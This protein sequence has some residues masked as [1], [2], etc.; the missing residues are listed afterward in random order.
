MLDTLRKY[1]SGWVA[2]LLMAVLVLSFAVWGVSD[3]F[4]GFGANAIAQVGDA[5][6]SLAEF[7]RRYDLALRTLSARLGQNISPQQA[8]QFGVP[9]QVLNQ[10]VF[11]ATLSHAASQMGIG[12][13]DQELGRK[14]TE[15]PNLF[16]PSGTFDRAY[17]NNLIAAQR[18][19]EDQFIIDRRQ[20]YIRD[21]IV[22]AFGGGLEAPDAYMRAIH[23]YTSE[24]RTISYLVV[25]APA[26]ADIPDPSEA[27]LA[28]Y[29][30]AHKADWR[31]PELRALQYFTLSPDQIAN[32]ADVSDAA[33]EQRYNSQPARFSTPE[34]RDVQQI[35]FKDKAAA[36]A[37]A[38]AL[39]AGKTFDDIVAEQKLKPDD[40]DLGLVT[41]DKIVDP[42][43]AKA[44]F[45]LPEGGV[46]GVIDGQFGPVILHVTRI[47]PAVE[48][49]FADVKDTLKKEIATER[50]ANDIVDLHNAIEDARAGGATL[51]EVAA[52]YDLKLVTVPAVDSDGNGAD[53]QPV[54]DLP[55]GLVAAAFQSDV[56]LENNPIEPDRNSYAWY[57]V[58]KT[59]PPRD[60]TLGEVHDRVVA[61]WKTDQR[62]QK[63]TAAS[64]DAR[65][66]LAG[67]AEIA[68]VASGL[69]LTVQT[70][71]HLT[72]R[73]QPTGDLS[74]A[75]I[76]AAFTGPKGTVEAADGAKPMTRVVLVVEEVSTPPYFSG[77]P[78][79]A[80]AQVQLSSQ[81]ENDLLGL[82]G[83]EVQTH[84]E[85]RLNQAALQQA[86]GVSPN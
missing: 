39:N 77:A 81:M 85:V 82:Y 32:P 71:D 4:S 5:K 45:S 69:S 62:Q 51:E 53:G 56:G 80:Q 30:A 6:V 58:T 18:M 26:E 31:A 37:A 10:L 41:R 59:T 27:E 14:I 16:G 70:A 54:A 13:S 60:R 44:A 76:Q 2:Q 48:T 24:E 21:Q 46:S 64:D 84:T 20:Q 40:V 78:E 1:A 12:I 47:E 35:V 83:A 29:F 66:R 43:V 11:E 72:R 25:S 49:P 68:T 52:S 22:D 7:Q 65:S 55:N 86:L 79:L 23:Q 19:T 67:G 75:V 3:I 63:L 28:D 8:V 38:A 61:A 34:K 74:A 15:D 73:T 36:T 57:T 50:A 42:A 17:L 9:N 33:A